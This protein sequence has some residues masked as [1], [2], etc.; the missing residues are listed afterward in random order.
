MPIYDY[1]CPNS[2]ADF[3][4]RCSIEA[5]EA[6]PPCCP[7]CASP[8][9]PLILQA[10]HVCTVIVPTYPG[11]KAVSAGYVHTH[12]AKNATKLTSGPAGMTRPKVLDPHLSA[13]YKPDP[14]T[15]VKEANRNGGKR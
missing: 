3:E 6:T 13:I 10:P 15:S 14:K 2:H 9:V 11:S 4:V 5:R 8:G 7:V 1:G 12:G